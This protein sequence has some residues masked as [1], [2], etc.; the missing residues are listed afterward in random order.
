[1]SFLTCL[2]AHTYT[3]ESFSHA[4]NNPKD[5]HL[6][7]YLFLKFGHEFACA[8]LGLKRSGFS[9]QKSEFIRETSLSLENCHQLP[10]NGAWLRNV[11]LKLLICVYVCTWQDDILYP[12]EGREADDH[13]RTSPFPICSPFHHWCSCFACEVQELLVDF[14][15]ERCRLRECQKIV[16]SPICVGFSFISGLSFAW[17]NCVN[18]AAPL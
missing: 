13:F 14:L 1:M 17:R 15:K 9:F 11:W 5:M 16:C 10:Q 3:S 4:M 7:T 8:N 2:D 18:L 6:A 12:S